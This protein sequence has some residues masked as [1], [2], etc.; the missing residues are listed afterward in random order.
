MLWSLD[1]Q[2]AR[3]AIRGVALRLPGRR[4]GRSGESLQRSGVEAHAGRAIRISAH[5]RVGL[6]LNGDSTSRRFRN[7]QERHNVFS[8]KKRRIRPHMTSEMSAGRHPGVPANLTK[9]S[10][11]RFRTGS[12]ARRW[13]PK[14]HQAGADRPDPIDRAEQRVPSPEYDHVQRRPEDD[15]LPADRAE[16]AARS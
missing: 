2:T 5:R 15:D 7:C 12:R 16:A 6:I 11:S 13:D 4:P 8:Q 14:T 1:V 9:L 3:A 10:Y